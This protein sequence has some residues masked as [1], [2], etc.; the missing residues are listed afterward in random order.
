MSFTNKGR[1]LIWLTIIALIG[2]YFLPP[3]S[4]PP[5]PILSSLRR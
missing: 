2:V 1:L 4:H 3:I 5:G